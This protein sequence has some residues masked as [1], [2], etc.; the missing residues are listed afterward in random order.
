MQ[1]MI[2]TLSDRLNHLK[3]NGT[4]GETVAQLSEIQHMMAS[5]QS[6]LERAIPKEQAEK[7]KPTAQ[8]KEA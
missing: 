4:S 5:I 2:D 1:E 3:S 7:D 6:V 8:S